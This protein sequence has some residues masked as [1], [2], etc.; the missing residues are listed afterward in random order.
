MKSG[1]L[2]FLEPSGPLQACNGNALPFYPDHGH[3]GSL[4]LTRKN[5]HGRAGNR[6]RDLMVSS[7]ELWPP[8]SFKCYLNHSNTMYSSGNIDVR[9]WVHLFE[10]RRIETC[11][12]FYQKPWSETCNMLA[13]RVPTCN[14]IIFPPSGGDHS[15]TVPSFCEGRNQDKDSN[16]VELR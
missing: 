4:P 6:T 11:F 2:K 14:T 12:G 1:N 3:H 13:E 5:A 8:S 15:L 10:S 7:Q 16:T 9:N